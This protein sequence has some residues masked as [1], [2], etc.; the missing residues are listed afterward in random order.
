MCSFDN[1]R[2]EETAAVRRRTWTSVHRGATCNVLTCVRA[3][4][5]TIYVSRAKIPSQNVVIV[6]RGNSV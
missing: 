1:V 5:D 2:R 4:N 3:E 6:N